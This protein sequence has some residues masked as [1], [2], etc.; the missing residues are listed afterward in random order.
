MNLT[1]PKL[2]HRKSQSSHH[3]CAPRKN[4]SENHIFL[5]H[6]LQLIISSSSSC[7]T[8]S[9]C[10]LMIYDPPLYCSTLVN[11]GFLTSFPFFSGCMGSK[12]VNTVPWFNSL[13]TWI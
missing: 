9:C 2:L 6:R 10:L 8:L 7:E 1:L 3:N 13:S 11:T 4:S 12:T 5:I